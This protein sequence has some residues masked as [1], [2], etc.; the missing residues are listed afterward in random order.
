MKSKYHSFELESLAIVV[1]LRKFRIYLEGI[2]IKIFTDCNSLTHTLQ[3]KAVNP[4]IACWAFEIENF[5]YTIQHRSGTGMGHVDALSRSIASVIHESAD[6]ELRLGALQNRDSNIIELREKLQ[7]ESSKLFESHNGLIYRKEMAEDLY[8]YVPV[9]MK[10]NVIRL[11]HEKIGH[12][13]INKTHNQ[14][15]TTYWLP[16]MKS[17]VETFICSREDYHG[18]P[19]VNGQ[20]E[21]IN[22][23]IKNILAI[24]RSNILIGL[25]IWV[26]W[27]SR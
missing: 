27:N 15:R 1:A 22:R 5:N 25:S 6:L 16:D 14:L 8:F 3:R 7:N 4:R 11:I 26:R 9:E 20:I 17:S 19:Q 10:G 13:G 2:S 23:I 12:L 21:R 24:S 18:S